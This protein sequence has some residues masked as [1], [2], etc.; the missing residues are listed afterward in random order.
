MIKGE[1]IICVSSIDW[2]FVWQGH[3]EIMSTFAK[4]GNKV[5]FIEN[6]GIRSPTFKDLPRL[7]KRI[8]NWMRS[9]KGF[10]QK[11][12]N[13]FVYSPLILPFPYS[14]I[15]RRINRYF[16]IR[17][18]RRWMRTMEFNN[19]IV[20]T[21]LPNGITLD[22][23]NNI[24]KK[25]LIYYCIADFHQ[26]ADNPKKVEKTENELIKKSDLIFAQGDFLKERCLRLN[27]NVHI[28]PFGVNLDTFD[29]LESDKYHI[30]EDMRMIKRPIVGYI[31]GIHRH[32]DF[33]LLRLIAA[34]HPEWSVVLVGPIQT[35]VSKISGLKNIFLLGKKEFSE[36]PNYV[37]GFD[38]GIIPYALNDYTTTVFPTKL[39]EYHA[40][41]KPVVSTSLPEILNFNKAH[42][43]LVLV[44]KN[45]KEFMDSV[46]QAIKDKDTALINRRVLSAKSNS[47]LTKIEQMNSLIKES[48]DEKSKIPFNWQ[49][50]FLKLY[51]VSRRKALKISFVFLAAYLAIFYTPFAWF[52]ASPLR[53]SDAPV[54]ADAIVV[55]A[56]GVGESGRPGQGYEE[57]V[58]HAVELYNKG[59]AENIIFSSGSVSTFPEPYV[60]KALAIY[61]GVAE[62]AITIEDRAASTYENVKFTDKIL[63]AKK[64]EKIILISSPY[65]MRRAALV[66]AKI[67]PEK[68]IAFVPAK[69]L[70]YSRKNDDAPGGIKKFRQID[71][72]QISGI[73]HEYLAICYYWLRGYI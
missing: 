12:E 71:L 46:S 36:L 40:M 70:F 50:S 72:R 59:F 60:M 45:Y 29:S 31:G 56:G 30:P 13:I 67:A 33:D 21:F 49:E 2:D 3:Q 24:D 25:L 4:N 23:V 34:E 38:A 62:S 5:L 52:M 15:A 14:K 58:K 26:L 51:K 47:W 27:N 42:D 20:W 61:L 16:L 9:V 22:I 37:N 44:G 63:D 57:R 11:M 1:N 19:P 66:F 73:L 68:K 54:K 39:N 65:H 41:G 53:I 69:S 55:F 18:L 10:R 28:F 32:I 35:D 17:S 43:G 8:I 6:T 64:W 48:I 7:K